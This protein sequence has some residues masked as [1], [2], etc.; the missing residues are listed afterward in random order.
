[1][2]RLRVYVSG[3]SGVVGHG[4]VKNIKAARPE[5]EI[6]GSALDKFNVGAHLVDT[7]AVCPKSDSEEYLSWLRT[8][9]SRNQ[10]NYAIPGIEIDLQIWNSNRGVFTDQNCIPILNTMEL[11]NITHDKFNFY[12]S[13]EKHQFPHSIPTRISTSYSDLCDYFGT[14]KLIAKP[15]IGF[16]KRGFLQIQS[17]SDFL[18]ALNVRNQ[19]LIFQPNLSSDGYEYT[20]GIFGDDTGGFSSIITLRRRL[21]PMGYTDY[22]ELVSSDDFRTVIVDYCKLFNPLGPTNFQFMIM[23]NQIFLLEIN[24]RFSSS[25]SMRGIFGYN[26]SKMALD[27]YE[28]GILPKQP[29][30]QP[31]KVLRYIE[32]FYVSE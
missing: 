3:V 24:P 29:P 1:V 5:V 21:S 8:F 14:R 27:F 7:F 2:R 12:C 26:E 20:S 19:D 28:K 15:R 23:K 11:I 32:D 6:F 17:E 30:L 9:L 25:T 4:V 18:E 16:A 31:G 13:V 22:A 10:I